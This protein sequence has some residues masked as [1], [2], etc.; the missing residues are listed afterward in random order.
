MIFIGYQAQG[1]LGRL[2]VDGAQHIKLFRD[3]YAVRARIET[4]GGFSAHAGQQQLL[5]W[6]SHFNN[7]PQ[8]ALVHGELES[9]QA[10]AE[11]F[12]E[13]QQVQVRIPELGETLEF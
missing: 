3:Q 13:E 5:A 2:M 6:F 9:L 10:L 12:Q 8:L 7:K 1:T 11:K 4:L